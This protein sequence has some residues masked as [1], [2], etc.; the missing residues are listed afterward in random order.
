MALPP[1]TCGPWQRP[2]RLQILWNFVLAAAL[3][4]QKLVVMFLLDGLLPGA[5]CIQA[6]ATAPHCLC[7]T[8]TAGPPELAR[9]P[10]A[11]DPATTCGVVAAGEEV[12]TKESFVS[13]CWRL[14]PYW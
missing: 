9:T 11:G 3:G 13:V 7:R 12:V 4:V 6:V 8:L 2:V 5:A 1:W 14:I 10:A